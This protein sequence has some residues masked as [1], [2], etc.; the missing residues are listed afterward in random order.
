M[1]KIKEFKTHSN[2]N[3]NINLNNIYND[4]E[5]EE[6]KKLFP[7]ISLLVM[8]NIDKINHFN[9][10]SSKENYGDGDDY[11]NLYI[12]KKDKNNFINHILEK[13][14][15]IFKEKNNT[16]LIKSISFI[17][18]DIE[19]HLN[20]IK[21]NK[22]KSSKIK[23]PIFINLKENNGL[24]KKDILSKKKQPHKTYYL[25]KSNS[26]HIHSP[27]NKYR[28]KDFIP[29]SS[30]DKSIKNY[31]VLINNSF[32]NFNNLS[33]KKILNLGKEN[34]NKIKSIKREL[35]I[36]NFMSYGNNQN[37]SNIDN[38]AY[39]HPLISRIFPK[40][41]KIYSNGNSSSNI[42][43][44]SRNSNNSEIKNIFPPKTSQIKSK[45]FKKYISPMNII[46]NKI[47]LK[48]QNNSKISPNH[49]I[50]MSDLSFQG[51]SKNSG[52]YLGNYIK[53]IERYRNEGNNKKQN[54]MKNSL[55]NFQKKYKI[56][57]P[58]PNNSKKKIIKKKLL[59]FNLLDN[60]II[61]NKDFDIFEFDKNVGKENTLL[62]ISNYIFKKLSFS[63]IIKINKFNNWC[64]KIA[65]GYTRKVKYHTDL[66]ASDVTHTCFI[67]L[68]YGKINDLYNFN[69]ISIC[70]LILSCICHD[71]KH[72]GLNNNFLKETN[73]E[74]AIRYND[75]SI[76]ENMHISETFKLINHNED[77]N[78]FSGVDSN[79]YKQIR[80]EMISNV[81]STDMVYH[82]K[83][84]EFM[85]DII[86]MKK[87]NE[88]N[89][90]NENNN[91]NHQKYME[92]FIH[93]SDLSNPTKPFHIYLKWA[94]LIVEEFCQQGDKEKSL[95]LN[96]TCD[97]KTLIFNIYQISFIDNV[98]IPFIS[99]FTTI[100]TNLKYL[101]EKCINNRDKFFNFSNKS[102]NKNI[103][104]YETNKK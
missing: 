2:D 78:I 61:E 20:N 66:H 71:Y 103:I 60:K 102:N 48:Q 49:R 15:L 90:K 57:K 98:I 7:R 96:C 64:K 76:L 83:H 46:Q 14:K 50:I 3:T 34:E 12:D 17:L 86:K 72:P 92:L 79:T 68:Q 38:M 5:I 27:Y 85:K 35:F 9:N 63:S 74:L 26:P 51:N 81:L 30:R 23:N 19:K 29:L 11:L 10:P 100:F 25:T 88:N 93:A 44:I 95:G 36:N 21:N 43:N 16:L 31:N 89:E 53:K 4:K 1:D 80:K 55:T 101:H 69:K 13:A 8:S 22:K 41:I 40:K 6:I 91:T 65:S 18:E 52:N 58:S 62:F 32:N 94:K 87:N 56:S 42:F 77:C 104:K 33:D 82:S 45:I 59:N 39:L 28:S 37:D 84:I 97:R 70:S 67:Y 99:S 54:I 47:F 24:K 73:N 75:V